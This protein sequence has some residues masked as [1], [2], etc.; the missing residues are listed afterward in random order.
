M[1]SLEMGIVFVNKRKFMTVQNLEQKRT[2]NKQ[3]GSCRKM[4][5]FRF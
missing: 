2:M 4:K 3:L 5:K 1:Y